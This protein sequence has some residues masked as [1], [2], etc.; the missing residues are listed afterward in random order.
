MVNFSATKNY[1]LITFVEIL[2]PGYNASA[3]IRNI[4]NCPPPKKTS[5][6]PIFRMSNN[7]EENFYLNKDHRSSENWNNPLCDIVK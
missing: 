3:T 7:A 4:K 5:A 2:Y 1:M 6:P